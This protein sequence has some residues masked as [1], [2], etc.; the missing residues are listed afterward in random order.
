MCLWLEV[1]GQGTH[2]CSS[3]PW[4]WHRVHSN[5][6][7]PVLHLCLWPHISLNLCPASMEKTIK[8]P[9][10]TT[11]VLHSPS[12]LQMRKLHYNCAFARYWINFLSSVTS[13]WGH[14]QASEQG[15][16]EVC[17]LESTLDAAFSLFGR[18]LGASVYPM[19]SLYMLRYCHLQENTRIVVLGRVRTSKITCC[20]CQTKE[21]GR[22]AHCISP[23]HQL[24]AAF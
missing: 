14:K 16:M 19:F 9:C 10:C 21:E 3:E 6:R 23:C 1:R 17:I 22:S 13:S 18:T 24:M 4:G 15:R 2:V 12:Q 7:T 20:W 11:T 8:F 5:M